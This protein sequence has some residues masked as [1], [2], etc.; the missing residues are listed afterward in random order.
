LADFSDDDR[1]MMARALALSSDALG[2]TW[3]NPA[4]GAVLARAG[5]VIGEGVTQPGG[6][7]HG[8]AMAIDAVGDAAGATLYVALEPC[9][10]RSVRGGIPCVERTLNA[11]IRRV[12]SAV[13]DPNPRIAGLGHA[14]LRTAG[15]KVDVGL[16][17]AEAAVVHRGHFK[18]VREGLPTVTFKVARTA[19]GYAGGVGKTRVAISGLEA[20]TWVHTTRAHFDAIMIG[21]ET[22]LAD[23]PQLNVRLA[24]L[25]HRSPVRVVLDSRL[26]LN[27]EQKLVTTCSQIPTWVIAAEDAPI[28]PERVLSARGVEVMR[29]ARGADGHLD[30]TEALK[31]LA[32][33]G[34]TRVFSEGGPTVGEQLALQGLA[35]EIIVS[36]SPARLDAPGV[37]AV[38][39]ALAALL[40]ASRTYRLAREKMIGHDRFA[41]YERQS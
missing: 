4:V 15:V 35:D 36:T 39:P 14:L 21:V 24:G 5:T 22:A 1:R 11:G 41:F 7:P 3:P 19:D 31:L 40:S 23:D 29:V 10:Y 9:A 30:L 20:A 37:T 2:T 27:P 28:E 12:V 25:E 34:I 6:R 16:M 33:R 8:E 26:R 32:A 18:R 17:E 13:A 38:R